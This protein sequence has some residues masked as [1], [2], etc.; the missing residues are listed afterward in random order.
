MADMAIECVRREMEVYFITIDPLKP[1]FS[2]GGRETMVSLLQGHSEIKLITK[3]IG[4]QF[5]FGTKPFKAHVY[6]ELLKGVPKHANI[7][8]SDD[9]AVWQIA[10]LLSKQYNFIGVLHADEPHYYELAKKYRDSIDLFVC[11]SQRISNTL[12]ELDLGSVADKI[13][14][15]PCGIPLPDFKSSTDGD[16]LK[17]VYAGRITQYQKRVF[18]IPAICRQLK[19]QNTDFHLSVIGSGH[20]QKQLEEQVASLGI[21][22]SVDFLGWLSK[23]QI[24]EHMCTSDL[25]L[26]TSDFEG[27]PIAVMEALSCGCGVVST[28]VSGVEDY[29]FHSLAENCL[30]LYDVGN[31]AE[32]AQKIAV[33]KTV[34]GGI[35]QTAAR[36]LAEAEF[37]ISLCLEEYLKAIQSVKTTFKEP[38]RKRAFFFPQ[39]ICSYLL[40]YTRFLRVNFILRRVP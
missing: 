6:K 13:V 22:N 15:I 16:L 4:W 39:Y 28:R 37:N 18:D 26:L 24:F 12:R 32:A 20:D 17:I 19:E 36:S 2:S 1:F 34:S 14:T 35:R 5:E 33:A 38:K 31:I 11:V 25:L 8:L 10:E 29:E 9:S 30:W 27:M 7:V 3:K 21:E 40:S 23:E